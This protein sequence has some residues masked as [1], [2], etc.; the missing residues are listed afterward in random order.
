MVG[1]AHQTCVCPTYVGQE[2]GGIRPLRIE[3][4]LT[5]VGC[6]HH[7]NDIHAEYII[8]F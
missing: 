8:L 5:S 2:V 6:A 1:S 3:C 4:D 7:H